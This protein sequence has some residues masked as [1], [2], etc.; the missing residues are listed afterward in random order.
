MTI[1]HSID[2]DSLDLL[3]DSCD[4]NMPIEVVRV[5]RVGEEPLA[6]GRLLG[7]KDALVHVEE[8]RI[9]GRESTLVQNAEVYAYLVRQGKVFQFLSTIREIAQPVR[10]NAGLIVPGAKLSIPTCL[11]QTQRRNHFRISTAMNK[12]PNIASV[13]R[14]KDFDLLA[15]SHH[16]SQGSVQHRA[17]SSNISTQ[18]SN[19]DTPSDTQSAESHPAPTFTGVIVD[20]S[21]SGFAMVV[22]MSGQVP[23]SYF[24]KLF[25]NVLDCEENPID[26]EVEVR[27]LTQLKDKRMKVGVLIHEVD[28]DTTVKWSRFVRWA[29]RE[30]LRRT[31]PK[32]A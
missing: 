15:K 1:S 12:D 20:V 18:G 26:L 16:P 5:N 19:Q 29:E 25:V 14:A 24:E 28:K 2:S 30:L 10:V 32:A 4:R 8:L 13:W 17:G 3:R 6:K 9:I 31:Q 7:I 11:V 27:R 23:L 22:E 21:H